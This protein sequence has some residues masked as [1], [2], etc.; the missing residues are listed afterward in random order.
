M[1]LITRPLLISDSAIVAD[2]VPPEDEMPTLPSLP[3]PTPTPEIVAS[4][5]TL[6]P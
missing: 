5:L 2:A 3:P 1:P 6:T 4:R